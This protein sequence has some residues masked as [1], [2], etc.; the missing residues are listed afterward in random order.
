VEEGTGLPFRKKIIFVPKMI[1][2]SVHILAQ[3]LTG[4]KHG[5]SLEALGHAFYGSI[6]K[7]S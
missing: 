7:R 5:Q 1:S 6:V 2:M 4:R 3:F